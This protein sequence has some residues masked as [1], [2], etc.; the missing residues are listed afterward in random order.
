MTLGDFLLFLFGVAI[1]FFAGRVS[2][3]H[4]LIKAVV[5]DNENETDK[6]PGS[7]KIEK[8]GNI[9]YAY[10]G[11]DFAGQAATFDELF[12]NMAKNRQFSTWKIGEVPDSLTN[13]EKE[14]LFNAI[15]KNFQAE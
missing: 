4:S 10:V 12:D 14:S 1:V 11:S 13:E 15:K 8:I 9:Y 2:M 5:N 3:M 6:T 7:L